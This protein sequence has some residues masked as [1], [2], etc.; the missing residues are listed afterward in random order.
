MKIE[1]KTG[2]EVQGTDEPNDE[3]RKIQVSLKVIQRMINDSLFKEI[4]FK[5][6]REEREL[7]APMVLALTERELK[8]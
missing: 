4:F 2:K 7:K 1:N 3:N 6:A 8:Q 5:I